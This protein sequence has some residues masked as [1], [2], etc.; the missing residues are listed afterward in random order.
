MDS[1]VIYRSYVVLI[2][3]SGS[4]FEINDVWPYFVS[5]FGLGADIWCRGFR[6]CSCWAT[7]YRFQGRI[8]FGADHLRWF[9][10]MKRLEIRQVFNSFNLN[11]KKKSTT[12]ENETHAEQNQKTPTPRLSSNVNEK[13]PA[14]QMSTK[15]STSPLNQP[16]SPPPRCCRCQSRPH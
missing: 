15:Q 7:G 3:W 5:G 6:A 16:R 10:K 12:D 1:Y 9:R 2:P 14:H 13:K 4:W 8:A 11:L